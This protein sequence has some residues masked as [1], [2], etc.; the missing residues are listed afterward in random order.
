MVKAIQLEYLLR[1]MFL[2]KVTRRLQG[3]VPHGLHFSG[4]VTDYC[5]DRLFDIWG[6][7]QNSGD[8]F[9]PDRISWLNG[10]PPLL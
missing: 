4:K 5:F 6:R 9:S 7:R 10:L 3:K 8:Y 1:F 2:V